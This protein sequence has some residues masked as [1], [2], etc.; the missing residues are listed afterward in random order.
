[1][2]LPITAELSVVYV[3]YLFFLPIYDTYILH[4][5]QVTHIQPVSRLQLRL[6]NV[7]YIEL[8]IGSFM[9]VVCLFLFRVNVQML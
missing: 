6:S 3:Y 2:A 7:T 1:M 8:Y 4:I 9:S 5:F